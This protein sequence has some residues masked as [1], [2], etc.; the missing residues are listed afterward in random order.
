M[1]E[2]IDKNTAEIIESFINEG[3]ERI[4]DSETQINHI[5]TENYLEV[6]NTIFRLFHSLKGSAGYLNFD[7]IKCLTHEAE[8]LLEIF[9]VKKINPDQTQIDLLFQTIDVLKQMIAQVQTNMND[10]G[11]E[12]ISASAII[13][14]KDCLNLIERDQHEIENDQLITPDMVEKFIS[15]TYELLDKSENEALLL[16]KDPQ[17]QSVIQ[18]IFRC[19]HTIKGNSGFLGY[20]V[21]EKICMELETLLDDVRKEKI[22]V[23]NSVITNLLKTIDIIRKEI[24]PSLN[25]DSVKQGETSGNQYKPLGEILVDMG[26]VLGEDVEKAL[27]IQDRPIGE[28]LI[29][30]GHVN[31]ETVEK[32]LEIQKNTF[33]EKEVN[34]IQDIQRKEIR[35]NTVKLDKL[36]DLV[37]ELITAEAMVFNSPD[38]QGIK[39]DKFNKSASAL[40]KI[41]RELQETTMMIRMIPLDGLFN[42]L[43]RLVRDLSKKFNKKIDLKITGQETE[44]DKNV[45]E[46]ISDP[47]VHIL[48][49]AI[50]HGIELP[51][52]RSKTGKEQTGTIQLSAKYEGSDIWLSVKDDGKGLDREKIIQKAVEKGLLSE[53]DA[54][55]SDDEVWQFIFE[56]G[57]STADKVSEVSGRGV[58]M[59]VVRKNMEKIKGKIEIKSVAGKGSEFIMKIPLTMAI[60][61]GITLKTGNNFYS[62]PVVDILEF[63]KAKDEMLTKMEDGREVVNLRGDIIPLIRLYEVF[64]LKSKFDKVTDGIMIVVKSDAKKACIFIDEIIGNQQLVIKS[65]S[66][67]L[68][69]VEG[70]SGCSI[71]GDGNVSF[72]IDT[73]SFISRWVE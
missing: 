2:Q 25:N 31:Q 18:E 1:N 54:D 47:L 23:N 52:D 33:T 61:D 50:D 58:G 30:A 73:S 53:P 10:K 5:C 19:I 37:G 60:I 11:T 44:M 6:V 71:L 20:A 21:I 42:K 3:F 8:T 15:E 22:A 46:Q 68:G 26:A 45:I 17:N 12:A 66:D 70:I 64:K 67:Y 9:R 29:E 35:V 14:I 62:I 24:K 72:I 39:L 49:N 48:R 43:T 7:N 32:A 51:I 57:L 28:I 65:I 63:F 40:S 55:L 34:N 13:K 41:S 38:I 27:V 36:F 4:E 16:D 56:P 59:D 69:T